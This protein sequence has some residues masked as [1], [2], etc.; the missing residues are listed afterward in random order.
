MK[1]FNYFYAFSSDT[2]R[3]ETENYLKSINE[4]AEQQKCR[5]E[6]NILTKSNW[7]TE[8]KVDIKNLLPENLKSDLEGFEKW[9]IK[10]HEG[11]KLAWQG[12]LGTVIVTMKYG[13]VV[14]DI[15][16]G[17]YQALV[18]MLFEDLNVNQLTFKEI[19]QKL[20]QHEEESM[21]T[22]SNAQNKVVPGIPI[23]DLKNAVSSIIFAKPE[24]RVLQRKADQKDKG[25]T[26]DDDTVVQFNKGFKSK[27]MKFKIGY[28]ETG[29]KVDKKG[30]KEMQKAIQEDRS[31]RIDA[32]IVRVM[33]TK[34]ELTHNELMIAVKEEVKGA[35][36]L[37]IPVVKKRIEN[38]ISRDFLKRTDGDGEGY[39]YLA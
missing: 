6:F 14:H 24:Q 9:Y 5:A 35:F 25:T 29:L 17:P 1:I 16:I 39:E 4:E 22:D 8:E 13:E 37:Q 7:P 26:I 18:L 33:K 34:K 21:T 10:N 31:F 12:N 2:S 32:I 19:N 15:E 20:G 3:E 38:L 11:R 27:K 36:E 30:H 23:E 28:S